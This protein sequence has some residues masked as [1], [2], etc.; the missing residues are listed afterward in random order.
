MELP[1]VATDILGCQES[2][3]D[4]VTG[5][6]VPVRNARAL[7]SALDTLLADSSKR[8]VLGV[9]GR[10]RVVREFR[11]EII[12]D[13][14]LAL[15]RG[16]SISEPTAGRRRRYLGKRAL[17]IAVA[18]AGLLALFP[19]F[20]ILT[21]LVSAGLV[22]PVFFCQARP[23]LGG[24]P[25]RMWKFRTMT[26]GRDAQGQPLPDEQRLTRLGRFL[27]ATSLDELPE[28]WNVLKG[29]MSLVGPRPLLMEYLPL[30][31]P[32]QARRH[33][34]RPGITG[35][36]QVNGRNAL[37][38]EEK[39]A[40]DVWYVDHVCFG[41]DCLIVWRT[42]RQVFQREGISAEGHATMPKFQ[43]AGQQENTQ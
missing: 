1:V 36:A 38:W 37:S 16:L 4:G 15:Y 11:Q 20:L 29:N 22:S 27:R 31:T 9:N 35:W 7:A 6:L 23:G 32:E 8:D 34:V 39:F 43:G 2:T 40:F 24:K 17:D 12:W 10:E 19:L 33:E 25:F 3:Q 42:F 5:I 26:D 41:L 18:L 21:I 28:L 30:Y 14:L 13:G